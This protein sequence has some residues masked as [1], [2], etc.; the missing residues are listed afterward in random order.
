MLDTFMVAIYLGF[1]FP[2]LVLGC[3]GDECSNWMA[4]FLVVFGVT[5]L[6][7][8]PYRLMVLWPNLACGMTG[9]EFPPPKNGCGKCLSYMFVLIRLGEVVAWGAAVID[10]LI[11]NVCNE[12]AE[13][14]AYAI[15]IA[16][17]I[18]ACAWFTGM[19]LIESRT[20]F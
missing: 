4:L 8:V 7:Q 5:C 19:Y 3:I 15:M 17:P 9:T 2:S 16:W 20:G 13:D 6:V 18:L 10:V 1:G 14:F 12:E 11:E